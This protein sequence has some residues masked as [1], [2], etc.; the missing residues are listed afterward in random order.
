R[1]FFRSRPAEDA[2]RADSASRTADGADGVADAITLAGDAAADAGPT[3]LHA[4]RPRAAGA[5]G[6]ARRPARVALASSGPWQSLCLLRLGV[7]AAAGGAL[8]DG[9]AAGDRRPGGGAARGIPRTG[10]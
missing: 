9:T 5:D 1:P 6:R 10:E 4:E 8:A 7:T 2:R 3:G